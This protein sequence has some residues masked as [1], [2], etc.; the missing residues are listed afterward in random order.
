MPILQARTISLS[1]EKKI[2]QLMANSHPWIPSLLPHPAFAVYSQVLPLRDS[3]PVG[4]ISGWLASQ[5]GLGF[6]EGGAGRKIS[7][8]TFQA[9]GSKRKAKS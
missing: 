2:A 3:S 7:S 8:S 9:R 1:G 5:L 6:T 4:R